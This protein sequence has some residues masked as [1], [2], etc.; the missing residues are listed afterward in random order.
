MVWFPK[1]LFKKG[2]TTNCMPLGAPSGCPSCP[3]RPRSMSLPSAACIQWPIKEGRERPS[4]LKQTEDHVMVHSRF[5][6]LPESSSTSRAPHS[7]PSA[8]CC[9]FPF[10]LQR[11]I[12]KKKKKISLSTTISVS[13]SENPTSDNAQLPELRLPYQNKKYP[14]ENSE[15]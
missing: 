15:K 3:V 5:W 10:L 2:L 6:A 13:T 11:L 14:R 8:S 4:H 9:F 7:F 12:L 1:F